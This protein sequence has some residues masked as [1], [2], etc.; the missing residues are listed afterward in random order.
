MEWHV[1]ASSWPHPLLKS[2]CAR[3][4]VQEL[5]M[6]GDRPWVPGARIQSCLYHRLGL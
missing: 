3:V 5:M 4:L 6:G 2:L 1:S